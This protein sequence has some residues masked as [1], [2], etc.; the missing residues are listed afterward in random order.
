MR[1]DLEGPALL[2]EYQSGT[3]AA[4]LARKYRASLWS[5]LSRIRKAGIKVRSNKE[6]NEKRLNL[7]AEQGLRLLALVDG[8]LLGD[9]SIDPKGCLRLEQ[10]KRRRGWL[11]QVAALFS[12]LGVSTKLL[13]IPPRTRMLEGRVLCS[14]GGH[15]LYTPCYVEF[16]EQR[17]RWYPKGVKRVPQDVDLS[18][19]S[20][21]NWFAGDGTYDTSGSLFLCT[22][23]F[24][25]TEVVR[26]AQGRCAL[27]IHASCIPG[28]REAQFKVAILRRDEAQLFKEAVEAHLPACCYYKL[29]H[30]R[31]T[32]TI[33]ALS[34]AHR[35]YSD[36][37]ERKIV[38]AR[39]RGLSWSV[40]AVKF[41]INKSTICHIVK[42]HQR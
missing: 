6:Y 37:V 36:A 21:A 30:V 11:V 29:Q 16:Q 17:K 24:L 18:P 2:E 35:K 8:F 7:N 28:Q 13:K 33:E 5:V 41:G 9:G 26:L 10:T 23:G 34:R 12:K 31:P 38:A 20:L 15:L 27:G 19:C 25:K 32:L 42:R 40:L 39:M 4:A 3:S 22:D 14:K 1:S